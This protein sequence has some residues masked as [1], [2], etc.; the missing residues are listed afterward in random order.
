M[1]VVSIFATPNN[2]VDMKIE[3]MNLLGG[4]KAWE[5]DGGCEV[6]NDKSEKAQANIVCVTIER[7][8]KSHSKWKAKITKHL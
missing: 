6:Y 5:E 2:L 7:D 3:S 1:Y 4:H 8:W